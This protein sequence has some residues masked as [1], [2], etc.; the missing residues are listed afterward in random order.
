MV[1]G[2]GEVEG[3]AQTQGNMAFS[4]NCNELI[5]DSKS[6]PTV[7]LEYSLSMVTLQE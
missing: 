7:V 4:R 3:R 6:L 1:D 5:G 2:R